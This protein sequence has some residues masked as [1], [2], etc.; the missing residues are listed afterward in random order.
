MNAAKKLV[1]QHISQ[2][3]NHKGTTVRNLTLSKLPAIGA[4]LEGGGFAGITTRPDG[5]HCAV[6]LFPDQGTDLDWSAA[7]AWAEEQ[8]GELPSRPVAALLFA[9]LKD[10]LLPTWHWTADEDD[11]S[12]A[13]NCGFGGGTQLSSRKSYAG[14]AVAVRLIHLTA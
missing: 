5:T 2:P 13:W 10:R 3:S 11:A 7:K 14:S 6:V 9:N 4:P 8:G 1:P 12:C